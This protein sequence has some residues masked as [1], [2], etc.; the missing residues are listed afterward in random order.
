MDNLLRWS[1]DGVLPDTLM[2]IYQKNQIDMDSLRNNADIFVAE[3][4]GELDLLWILSNIP[5]KYLDMRQIVFTSSE[6]EFD[7]TVTDGER[8]ARIVMS[9]YLVEVKR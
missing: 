3:P 7:F 6:D 2:S 5:K 8:D 1:K 9:D 4:M